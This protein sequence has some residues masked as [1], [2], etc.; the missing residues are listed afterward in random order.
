MSIPAFNADGLLPAGV[1]DCSL[2][3][4]RE[5]LGSFQGSDARPRLFE[6]L[7]VVVA[8]MQRSTLFE[9]LLLDGS[10]VTAK[11]EP[12]DV[13]C[14]VWVP[15]DF[16]VQYRWGRLEAVK[17]YQADASGQPAEIYLVNEQIEWDYWVRLFGRIRE[18][19]K[20]RKGI[21]E[22]LL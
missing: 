5:R 18:D 19:S 20:K 3:D 16:D 13:D 21:V 22:V 10:F 1:F 4:V 9:V 7:E 14:A 2:A 12:N 17:L 6:R 15:R 11:D 8:A